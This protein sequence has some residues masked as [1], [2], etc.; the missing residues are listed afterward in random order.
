MTLPCSPASVLTVHQPTS[1]TSATLTLPYYL[2]TKQLPP[3]TG[4]LPLI[5][6]FFIQLT[7]TQ[8]VTFPLPDWFRQPYPALPSYATQKI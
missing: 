6:S 5:L 8:F 7:P 1:S 3:G 2:R 4:M